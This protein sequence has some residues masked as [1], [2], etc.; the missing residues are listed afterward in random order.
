LRRKFESICVL[1]VQ[2]RSKNG[3]KRTLRSGSFI[4][5]A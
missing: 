2:H 1:F 4:A 3:H 5:C